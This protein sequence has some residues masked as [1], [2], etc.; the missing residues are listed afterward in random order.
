SRWLRAR[1][2]PRLR[3]I[4]EGCLYASGQPS[5]SAYVALRSSRLRAVV[6]LRAESRFYDWKPENGMHA[7]PIRREQ[8]PTFEEAEA[9]LRILGDRES[10][11]LLVHS[12]AGD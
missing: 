1:G 5:H 12:A 4:A 9:F 2:V 8:P 11:P 7:L 10:W 3:M 6:N